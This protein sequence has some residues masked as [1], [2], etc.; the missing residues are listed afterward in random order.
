[1]RREADL[2]VLEGS[3]GGEWVDLYA[4]TLEP[5]Y[6]VD[7]ELAN[8]F[9]STHPRSAYVLNLT[10]QRSWPERRAI[11]RNR[12]LVVRDGA[13][14]ETTTIRDPEHLLEVLAATFDLAFPPGT[15]FLRPEF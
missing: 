7:F 14:T 6:P 11:L 1:V 5:H 12:E 15:R 9:T 13:A 2:L 3:L 4:F 8:Y 10:V